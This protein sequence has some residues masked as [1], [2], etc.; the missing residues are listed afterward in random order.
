MMGLAQVRI[1]LVEPAGARNLGAIARV[2]K[3][4]GLS[5]LVLVNPQCDPIGTEALHMAV[6]AAELLTG[7][8]IVAT[9]PEA[10]GGVH[11]AAATLGRDTDRPLQSPRQ[12][13]P[14]LLGADR[15]GDGDQPPD[16]ARDACRSA[17]IFGAEDHGLSNDELKYAQQFVMIP[18]S[19]AYPS[20]NLA[21]A[22]GICCYELQQW[23]AVPADRLE[24]AADRLPNPAD[25]AAALDQLEAF[26]QTLE[27]Q[28]LR[29]GYL[30]P[31]TASSRM[32]KLRR[33]L[34]RA[35]P[36]A[37]E[38]AMLRGMMRQLDWALG[39]LGG[40]ADRPLGVD[41]PRAAVAPSESQPLGNEGR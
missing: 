12:V 11:R 33:L 28:L 35:Q 19:P 37:P 20:L 13:A 10:L 38:V 27:A 15:A 23:G 24:P 1:V 31:H 26:Y 8:Q 32:D 7:A 25:P 6:H 29:I 41:P 5:H 34:L 14:W 4:M 17:L 36:T 18:A 21:Q 9:L 30:H 22:V 39:A 40:Q 16:Q 2:M 3:N